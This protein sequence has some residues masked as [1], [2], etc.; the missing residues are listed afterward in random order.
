MDTETHRRGI[1]EA[2]PSKLEQPGQKTRRFPFRFLGQ[3][4]GATFRALQHR[5]YRLYFFGLFVSWIGTW[6][7]RTAIGWLIYELTGSKMLL[8]LVAAATSGPIVLLSPWAGSFADRWSKRNL[9]MVT[10]VWLAL[11]AFLLAGLVAGGVIRPWHLLLIGTLEGLA[12]AMDIPTRQAFLVEVVGREDLANA[13]ALNASMV[14]AARILGPSLAGI[15]MASIGAAAC[16]AANGLSFMAVLVALVRMRLTARPHPARKQGAWARLRDGFRYTMRHVVLREAL[17]LFALV[18]IFGWSYGVLLPVYAQDVLHI[19]EKRYGLLLSTNGIGALF[20]ALTVARFA[21]QLS[22]Q[23][24]RAAGIS[25]FAFGLAALAMLHRYGPVLFVLWATGWGQMLFLSSTSTLIQTH[26]DEVFRSRV[27][28]IWTAVF[29]A[30]MPLGALQ[31]GAFCN[32]FGIRTVLWIGFGICIAAAGFAWTRR[33]VAAP[34]P[35]GSGTPRPS[36]PVGP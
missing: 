6:M 19:A 1:R 23:R 3:G 7:H 15:L 25:V 35:G 21:T 22:P 8:G 34:L 17:V 36:P 32:W 20:G 11:L 2:L 24:L 16:F 29:A 14:N 10:Q 30:V 9:L 26:V 27:M 18:G 4:L 28:G 31:A 12:M 33:V 13:V 5:N